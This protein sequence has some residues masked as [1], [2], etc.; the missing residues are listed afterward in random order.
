MADVKITN[1]LPQSVEIALVN[2]YGSP[3][4]RTL[5]EH[6]VLVVDRTQVSP[7]TWNLSRQG[8]ILIT[9]SA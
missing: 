7:Y 2:V 4:P 3:T 6:A 8:H 1:L 9:H 5:S